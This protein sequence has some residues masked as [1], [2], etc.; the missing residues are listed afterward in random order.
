MTRE[1]ECTLVGDG[2]S[3]R[4]LLHP[5]RWCLDQLYPEQLIN[6]QYAELR[7]LTRNNGLA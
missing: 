1:V 5:I 6:V 3:D 7:G 4:M 2:S